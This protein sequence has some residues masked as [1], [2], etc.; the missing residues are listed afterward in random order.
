MNLFHKSSSTL[1]SSRRK[2]V[3][4]NIIS[5]REK[6]QINSEEVREVERR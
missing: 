2:S 1:N 6:D 3:K 4:E 5:I